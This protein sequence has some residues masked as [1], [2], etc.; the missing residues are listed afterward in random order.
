[1]LISICWLP[2]QQYCFFFNIA[3]N[4]AFN[5]SLAWSFCPVSLQV[6]LRIS[7]VNMGIGRPGYAYQLEKYWQTQKYCQLIVFSNNLSHIYMSL[8]QMFLHAEDLLYIAG[9]IL[10][11]RSLTLREI[12]AVYSKLCNAKAE[13]LMDWS[14]MGSPRQG[15]VRSA[16]WLL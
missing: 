5:N 12:T 6:S 9:R 3:F 7:W 14:P 2:S 16:A 1:M 8:L 11:S 15:Q 10:P 4:I 13:I